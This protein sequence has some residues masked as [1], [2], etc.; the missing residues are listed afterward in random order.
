MTD[1]IEVEGVRLGPA[2]DYVAL[3]R[4]QL[5]HGTVWNEIGDPGPEEGIWRL[6]EAASGT[7]IEKRL[8]DA[9]M[10]LLTDADIDVR[11]GAVG[12]AQDYAEKMDPTALLQ[13]LERNQ[14]LFDGIKPTDSR[15]D[16]PDLAWGL[17]RALTANTGQDSHVLAALKKAAFDTENGSTVLGGLAAD[18]P[19]WIIGQ[20][21]HVVSNDPAKARIIMANLPRPQ[22]RERF[23]KALAEESASFREELARIIADKVENPE[24]RERLRSLL[25]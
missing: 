2:T 25:V 12:L 17:L 5:K 1:T 13:I 3:L 20:A 23:V 14:P 15:A 18:D 8:L 10:E 16:S 7:P 24:E 6:F 21:R 11:S 9:V 19:E 22:S 4:R